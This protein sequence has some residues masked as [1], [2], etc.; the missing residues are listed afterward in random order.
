MRQSDI[1]PLCIIISHGFRPGR[2]AKLEFPF[3]VKI[4]LLAQCSIR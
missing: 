4:D 1:L 2:V 3:S